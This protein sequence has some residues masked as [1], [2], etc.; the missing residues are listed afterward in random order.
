MSTLFIGLWAQSTQAEGAEHL[1]SQWNPMEYHGHEAQ[2]RSSDHN[3]ADHHLDCHH[4]CLH[5]RRAQT[6]ITS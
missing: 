2:D 3:G 5:E 6:H 1:V 4:I